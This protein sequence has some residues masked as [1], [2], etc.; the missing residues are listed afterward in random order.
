MIL[1]KSTSGLG[2][3]SF[4]H[5][6]AQNNEYNFVKI[7]C[8]YF[9]SD[10]ELIEKIKGSDSYNST[11]LYIKNI[12]W[13][14]EVGSDKNDSQEKMKRIIRTLE[15]AFFYLGDHSLTSHILIVNFKGNSIKLDM[16]KN[17]HLINF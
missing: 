15:E 6:L 10:K 7:N 12:E 13:L 11:I 14:L 5:K 3:S 1:L 8:N 16:T 17:A 4:L 9:V 2:M